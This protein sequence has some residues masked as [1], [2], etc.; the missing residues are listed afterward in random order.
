MIEHM[1]Y[2]SRIPFALS[3]PAPRPRPA[4]TGPFSGRRA[5]TELGMR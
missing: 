4:Q 3:G 2:M 5:E 1:F